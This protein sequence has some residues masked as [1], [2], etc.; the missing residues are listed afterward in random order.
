MA[1]AASTP[2]QT[3]SVVPEPKTDGLGLLLLAA[4]ASSC[5]YKHHSLNA[6]DS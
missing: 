2:Q 6:E 4:F 5:K 3:S 1:A